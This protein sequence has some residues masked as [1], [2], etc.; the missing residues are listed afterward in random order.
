MG[1]KG[2]IHGDRM[3]K[4]LADLWKYVDRK[5]P[6]DCW[7]WTR[8]MNRT[9]YGSVRFEGVKISAHRAAFALAIGGISL[10]APRDRSSVGFLLHSCDNKLCC[11]P[12]H[13]SVGSY[14][15]NNKDA[16]AK[17]RSRALRGGD[18]P[19]AS[20]TNK[21]AAKIRTLLKKGVTR[22]EICRRFNLP[23]W[24]VRRI[25]RN[26]GYRDTGI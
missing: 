16:A 26:E 23:E 4:E 14:Y 10:I 9:G 7:N 24:T 25:A 15:E 18:H 20:L 17:G 22:P 19:R 8:G 6:N 11:N 5:G 3:L 13:L 1:V 21:E 2:V 12:R